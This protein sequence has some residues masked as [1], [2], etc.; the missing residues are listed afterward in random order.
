MEYGV[1]D[2]NN[3]DSLIKPIIGK[4]PPNLG[5]I[6]ILISGEPDISMLCRMM[7]LSEKP[8]RKLMMSKLYCGTYKGIRLSIVG[9]VIGA[10]YATIILEEMIAWG[11]QNILFLGWCGSLSSKVRIGDIVVPTSGI[12]DEGTSKCYLSDIRES[13]PCAEMVKKIRQS[14]DFH[15]FLYKKGPVWCTDG[16]YQETPEKVV[17][18]QKQGAITVEMETSAL[19]TVGCFRNVSVGGILVV[20]DEVYTLSWHPGFRNKKFKT[21]RYNAM[22]VICRLCE[23]LLSSNR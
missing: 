4:N 2:D 1:K 21:G 8:D 9:P 22:K 6:T 15:N 16:I 19:F 10:P 23:M 12:I 17:F 3:M 14:F 20:S 11:A 18:Y 7:G 5:L 13:K